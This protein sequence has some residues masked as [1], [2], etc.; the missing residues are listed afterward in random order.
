MMRPSHH[1]RVRTDERDRRLSGDASPDRRAL[2]H[3][4]VGSKT[5]HAARHEAGSLARA[6][7][8]PDVRVIQGQSRGLTGN[9]GPLARTDSS[10]AHGRYGATD[11]PSW[12]CEFDSRRPLHEAAGQG[13][14]LSAILAASRGSVPGRALDPYRL[15]A[16][17]LL[18]SRCSGSEP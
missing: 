14:F 4:D 9:R 12:S 7:L 11:L 13:R 18:I 10:A 1:R 8:V 15:A 16:G 3:R 2:A 17:G 5:G 6:T